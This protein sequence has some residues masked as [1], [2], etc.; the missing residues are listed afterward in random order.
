MDRRTA[1]RKLN[2]L[3]R[4]ELRRFAGDLL[5]WIGAHAAAR[6]VDDSPFPHPDER[7]Q[8]LLVA[9]DDDS[10]LERLEHLSNFLVALV[11]AQAGQ[12]AA[13]DP[14][15]DDEAVHAGVH[16]EWRRHIDACQRALSF[17]AMA[18]LSLVDDTVHALDDVFTAVRTFGLAGTVSAFDPAELLAQARPLFASAVA[19]IS[20]IPMDESHFERLIETTRTMC[21]LTGSV[22]P[23]EV[24]GLKVGPTQLASK[25]TLIQRYLDDHR[26]FSETTLQLLRLLARACQTPERIETFVHSAELFV[27]DDPRV[28]EL[29]ASTYRE[30]GKIDVA[31]FWV[32]EGRIK[33]PESTAWDSLEE[34]LF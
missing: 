12:F 29:I 9:V 22:Q 17:D 23:W 33:H 32:G 25:S 5:R 28:I 2:A 8:L 26:E 1:R 16:E 31:R 18:G 3:N 19:T 11:R 27:E 20:S 30:M 14:V 24:V 7:E 10:T 15:L 34:R 21:V 13:L 6:L 4:Q